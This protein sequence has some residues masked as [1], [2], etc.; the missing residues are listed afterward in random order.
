MLIILTLFTALFLLLGL[1]VAPLIDWD[2]NIYA[3][4]SRQ[5]VERGD[6]LNVYINNYP[7]AEKPPFFFWA[8]SLSYHLFGINEFAARFP[9]AVAGLFAVWLCYYFGRWLE[10]SR[11]GMMWGLIYLTSFLPALFARSAVIDHTFNL[12]I[13]LAAF[14]LVCL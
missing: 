13:M 9:S 3:E 1:G 14:F 4:A 8:E 10:S 5:M 2:E 12:F 11:F 7:F 6:Y